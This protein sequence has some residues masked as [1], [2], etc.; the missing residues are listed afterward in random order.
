M[1]RITLALAALAVSAAS[2]AFSFD[3]SDWTFSYNA[4]LNYNTVLASG[5]EPQIGSNP[6][7]VT[8]SNFNNFS[9]PF[10]IGPISGQGDFVVAG[11]TVTDINSGQTTPPFNILLNNTNVLVRVTYPT[12]NLTGTITQTNP[13]VVGTFGTRAYQITGDPTTINNIQIEAFLFGGWQNLG[14]N[15]NVVISSWAMNR[16]ADPVPEP[17][18]LAAIA[19]ASLLTRVRRR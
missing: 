5:S 15:N 7:T 3:G 9:F 12:F 14:S 16:P 2:H 10:A 17:A 11:N 13:A 1:K 6:V 19:L 18:T 8:Q 4:T